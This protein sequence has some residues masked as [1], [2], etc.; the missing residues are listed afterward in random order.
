MSAFASY[1]IEKFCALQHRDG[2]AFNQVGGLEV[3]TTP[4]RRPI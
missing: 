4:E 1:T 2:R 3:A